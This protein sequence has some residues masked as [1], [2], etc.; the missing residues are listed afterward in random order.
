MLTWMLS[1]SDRTKL[2]LPGTDR[3]HDPAATL[4]MANRAAATAGITRV[5]DITWLDTIGIPTYQAIRPASL[6]V[7]VSQGKG[8]TPDLAKL[9]AMME[10]IEVWHAEQPMTPVTVAAPRDVADQLVYDLRELPLSSP[11]VLHDGLPLDWQ[12]ARSLLDGTPTLVPQ[13]AVGFS[14]ARRS[15]WNAPAFFASTNGLASGNT[16]AEA[17]LHALYEVIER[18]AVTLAVTGGDRGTPVDP[19]SA[20]SAAVAELCETLARAGVSLEVRS[21][22]SATE[23]PCFI[24]TITCADYPPPFAGYGCHLSSEIALTRAITEA[25]QARVA[26]ISGARDDLHQD[27]HAGRPQQ[28]RPAAPGAA[29]Q[30]QRA[31][32]SLAEDLEDVVKRA[33]VAFAHPPLVADLSRPGLGVPV[34]R[35]LAP[36]SRV[37]PEVF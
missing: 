24:A 28:R 34:V 10:A 26:Y 21:V 4:E 15:G 33:T 36:G 18:D 27:V 6:T 25:A 16:M 11:T 12:P 2:R 5:A 30:P 8:L 14:L 22:P 13:E 35:V 1:G 19:A 9:S 17:I 3:A 32:E 23:L 7:A 31:H 29:I 20:D 37:S